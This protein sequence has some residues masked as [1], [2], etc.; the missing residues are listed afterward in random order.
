MLT[1]YAFAAGP[2]LAGAVLAAAELYDVDVPV[3]AL[4]VEEIGRLAGLAGAAIWLWWLIITRPRPDGMEHWWRRAVPLV[5]ALTVIAA[6]EAGE[7]TANGTSTQVAGHLSEL[8]IWIWLCVEV[9]ARWG[10]SIQH[11]RLTGPKQLFRKRTKA[12]RATRVQGEMVFFAYAAAVCA[13]V[14]LLDVLKRL[15]GP[16]LEGDQAAAAGVPDLGPLLVHGIWSAFVEELLATAVVVAVL[17]AARRPL[18]EGL[19]VAALM[20]TL[21]HAYLGLWPMFAMLPLGIAAGWLY[22]RYRRVIPLILAHATY[23]TLNALFGVPLLPAVA[24]MLT[25]AIW[26]WWETRADN[27]A[28]V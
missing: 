15:P 26:A 27:K 17:T 8:V 18:W 12:E 11:L 14:L 4:R 3:A 2:H 10:L 20:R 7:F 21:P 22:H 24:L 6:D 28:H 23:N 25:A 13:A 16:V 9:T 1:L 5:G 19:V